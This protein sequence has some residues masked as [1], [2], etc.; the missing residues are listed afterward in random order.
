[1]FVYVR[2][3]PCQSL[4]IEMSS[5]AFCS[6]KSWRTWHE[7]GASWS[8]S[9]VS[10]DIV[11]HSVCDSGDYQI[12]FFSLWGECH[13]VFPLTSNGDSHVWQHLSLPYYFTSRLSFTWPHQKAMHSQD[14]PWDEVKHI[15]HSHHSFYYHKCQWS[16]S[17][18]TYCYCTGGNVKCICNSHNTMMAPRLRK[19]HCQI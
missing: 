1:M 11:F 19:R 3:Q 18:S 16:S 9:C 4:G 17:S 12:F 14:T 6:L 8:R 15:Q 2:F 5:M 10:P 7:P 13:S